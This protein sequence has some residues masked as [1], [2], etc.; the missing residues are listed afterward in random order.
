MISHEQADRF[1]TEWIGAWNAHDLDAIVA[2]YAEDV[3][4]VSPFVSAL[5]GEESARIEGRAGLREYFGRG[6]EAFPDLHFELY[7]ALPG[8]SSIALHYRSVGGRL[9]IETMEVDADGFVVRA[10]AHYSPPQD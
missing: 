1:A 8:V 2:H 4:F 5:T 10:A 3:V 9:A 7:T 6:L